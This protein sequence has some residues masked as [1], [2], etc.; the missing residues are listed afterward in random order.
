MSV[1]T[2]STTAAPARRL[3]MVVTAVAL[4]AAVLVVEPLGRGTAGAAPGDATPQL[5]TKTVAQATAGPG[6]LIQYTVNF[7]CSNND[8]SG[9]GCDGAELRDP[10]PTF[11]DV[12]GTA[13]PLEFVDATGPAGVWPSGF[14]VD[15][16][17]PAN[18]AIVGTAGSW[19]P[20]VSGSIFVTLRVPTGTVPEAPQAVTNVA[21][22]SDPESGTTDESTE[23]TTE[24]SATSP[25]WTISK[26][27]TAGSTRMNRDFGYQVSVCAPGT[28]AL[29]PIFEI[30]D[31][32]PPGAEFVSASHGGTYVDDGATAG[33]SD[34]AGEVAWI[35]DDANRA[36]IGSDG[37]FRTTVT[38]RWPSDY[39]DPA[40]AD[41]AND[42]NVGGARKVNQVVALGKYTPADPG[43][44]I[45]PATEETTLV[46]ATFGIGSGS[47]DKTFRAPGGATELYVEAGD[48]LDVRLAFAIDSDLPADR[49]TL[50]D[51]TWS[52]TDG[53]GTTSGAGMPE[54]FTATSVDAGTW[55]GAVTATLEG[56]AD[57]SSWTTIQ[58]GI[59]SGSGPITVDPTHRSLRLVWGGAAD[60]VPAD[61]AVTGVRLSD[62]SVG[63]DD[64]SVEPGRYTNVAQLR[65]ERAGESDSVTNRSAS[66]VLETPRPHP[67]VTKTVSASNRQPGQ[68]ATY[69][70]RVNN[71]GDAT[72]DLVDPY[73]TDC[74]PGH[75]IVQDRTLGAGWADGSPLPTCAA[76][77]TPLR[78]DYAGT[79]EPGDQTAAVTYQVLVSPFDP[80]D[81]AAIAPPG[82]YTNTV[83]VHPEGG[84]SFTHCQSTN[85]VCGRRANLTVVPVV[86]LESQKCVTG[87]LDAGVLRPSPGCEV[88]PAGGV[89]AAQTLP[90]G[91]VEW[92]LRLRN[93]GNTDAAAIDF[94]DI[95]PHV[96][97]TAVVTGDPLNAR[98]SEW[99]P[100]LASPIA[101]PA[102]WTVQYSTSAD[103][104]RPEVGHVGACDAPN[105]V[106]DPDLADLPTFRSIKVSHA[107]AVDS[108]ASASF[109][110]SMRAPVLDS[111]YDRDGIDADDP[112]ELLRVCGAQTP[113]TDPLHCPRA[114]N[115]FAF[116]ADA[117]NLPPGVPQPS[118]LYAEPPQV[119]VRVVAP[120]ASAPLG[121]GDRVWFDRDLDGIQDP[122]ETGVP[123]VFVELYEVVGGARTK[124]GETFTDADGNY[125]FT[126]D[127]D[128][129]PLDAGEFVVRFHPPADHEVSPRAQGSDRAVDSDVSRTPTL[130]GGPV[131]VSTTGGA[132]HETEPVTLTAGLD[133]DWDMGIWGGFDPAIAID[134]VTKESTRPDADARDGLAAG[135][136]TELDIVVDRPV[137]WIYTVTNTGDARLDDVVVTD[138]AGTPGEPADD[139]VVTACTVVDDGVNADGLTSSATTPMALNRGAVM[140]CTLEGTALLGAYLNDAQVVGEPTLDD[141]TAPPASVPATVTANDPSSYVGRAPGFAVGDLV[142]FDLDRNGVQDVDEDPVPGVTVELLDATDVVIAT[143]TTGPDGRY[144]FDDV[145][146]GTYRIRFSGVPEGYEFTGATAGSETSVDSDADPSGLTAPFSVEVNA[147]DMRPVDPAD[148]VG[149]DTNLIDPTIDAGLW[150]P[151]PDVEVTKSAGA[152]RVDPDDEVEWAV[153]VTNTGTG[154]ARTVVVVDSLPDGL[155]FTRSRQGPVPDVDRSE[156]TL[157]WTIE[158]VEPG[159][160][161]TLGY[162]TTVV[163]D[164]G[165][166]LTNRVEISGNPGDPDGSDRHTIVVRPAAAP[167][168]V[169][170]PADPPRPSRLPL[171]GSSTLLLLAVATAV[172]T[173]G[174]LLVGIARRRPR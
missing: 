161:V 115:S 94:I 167:D 83:T 114:V 138:D 38:V 96:G 89:V 90:G 91:E 128:G 156:G 36:P 119:E 101:A 141:G 66:Y 105:W 133:L 100:F 44:P 24:I 139:L 54:S 71:S 20:G 163:A 174:S 25:V 69:T 113:R 43:V 55:P 140:R 158:A 22:V 15:A 121:I 92:E 21:T 23:A 130:P 57:N 137:T 168:P 39:V 81:P 18:P 172:L 160:S 173:V 79:L 85:P 144:L 73:V 40:S 169:V 87:S 166:A 118:R 84:G 76:G 95:L 135:G 154:T 31:T 17:D 103:P 9:D 62:P 26:L 143:T 58:G 99:T 86:Q 16:T 50:T 64:P 13:S 5:L 151:T 93:V 149:P 72:G 35:F 49:V 110:W 126:F 70:V 63:T 19:A 2:P 82:I 59:S 122:G 147:P 107:G 117:A 106:S 102:G 170:A 12:F 127:E 155:V 30:T 148:P 171:T 1:R 88:D 129:Q 74:V 4:L 32:L 68:T 27:G 131:P 134:K 77:E 46:G 48:P 120:P 165:T 37:C 111:S 152:D 146:A 145:A 153:V 108:G 125:L 123:Y 41:P 10:I 80:D 60:S 61:F 164:G 52:Y 34:G 78:V 42:D 56:S 112:Y 104:C 75:L 45:G 7:T 150:L 98:L 47:F 67:G 162:V 29:Y 6:D 28:S 51:G 142:W 97:D 14:S 65:L 11:L 3:V 33:T 159:A 109:R 132:F 124:V 136:E 157:T 116:G 53:A 8:Q